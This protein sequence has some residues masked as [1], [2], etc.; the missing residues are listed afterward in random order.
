MKRRQVV[1]LTR[2]LLFQE[3]HGLRKQSENLFFFR[4]ITCSSLYIEFCKKSLLSSSA[5]LLHR[6]NAIFRIHHYSSM[7]RTPET[8][9]RVA[10]S[11]R[12]LVAEHRPSLATPP[13]ALGRSRA[14]ARPRPNLGWRRPPRASGCRASARRGSSR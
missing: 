3:N 12:E 5:P 11:N 7:F 4:G 14:S 2:L 8:K 1:F 10:A 9:T 13:S 6:M